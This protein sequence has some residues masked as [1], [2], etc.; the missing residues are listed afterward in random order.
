VKVATAFRRGAAV[1]GLLVAIGGLLFSVGGMWPPSDAT[2]KA[3]AAEVAAGR[4]PAIVARFTIPAPGCVCHSDDPVL[5]M[6]HS[7]RRVSECATCH[8]R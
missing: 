8:S 7:N 5:Q 3:Y 1:L 6:Q 4:Q 2:K